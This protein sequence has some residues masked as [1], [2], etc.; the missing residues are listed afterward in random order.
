MP[1]SLCITLPSTIINCY[2]K[3]LRQAHSTARL[4]LYIRHVA[5]TYVGGS[6]LD[7][8][9][10]KK[11]KKFS[12]LVTAHGF[13]HFSEVQTPGGSVENL[14]VNAILLVQILVFAGFDNLS[15]F[16]HVNSV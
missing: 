1:P 8:Q 2:L 13:E 5:T 10:E 12:V 6:S 16:H 9:S 7:H 3:I 11:I 4:G 14:P 15:L